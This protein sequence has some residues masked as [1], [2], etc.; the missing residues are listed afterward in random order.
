MSELELVI[1]VQKKNFNWIK[2]HFEP[3]GWE[4]WKGTHSVPIIFEKII[5]FPENREIW[6]VHTLKK[7]TVFK[8]VDNQSRF[9]SCSAMKTGEIYYTP[10]VTDH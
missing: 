5:W 6:G 4:S 2:Y 9:I 10:S 8:Y 7:N 3:I 1:C